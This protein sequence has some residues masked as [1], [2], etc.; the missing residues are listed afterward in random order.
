MNGLSQYIK[1]HPSNFV[2]D[3]T[4]H[5]KMV[6]SDVEIGHNPTTRSSEHTLK[7]NDLQ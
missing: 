1:T 2:L 4:L 6:I 5:Q 7:G 3:L